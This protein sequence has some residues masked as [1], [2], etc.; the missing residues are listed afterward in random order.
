MQTVLFANGAITTPI[1]VAVDTTFDLPF[2]RMVNM[3]LLNETL[4]IYS[5][6]PGFGR[7]LVTLERGTGVLHLSVIR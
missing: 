3:G 4:S 6:T 5:Q 7:H 2:A 1:T